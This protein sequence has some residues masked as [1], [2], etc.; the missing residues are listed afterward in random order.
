MMSKLAGQPIDILLVEDN[1]GD[2]RLT[3]EGLKAARIANSLHVA[4]NGDQALDY[5]YRRNGNANAPR[6]DVVLLDLDLPGIDGRAV[7]STIKD[8]EDLRRIPVVV[9]TSSEAETDI[10]KAYEAHANCYI[11][12][13]IDFDNFLNVVKS[14]E[15]F[16]LSVVRLP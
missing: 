1:P 12:K 14:I 13:P 11:A 15:N 9:L 5:L 2:V 4:A 7:L 16:W 10:V 8:D 3:Q 6:P